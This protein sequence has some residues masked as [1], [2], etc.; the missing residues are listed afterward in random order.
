MVEN[1]F[2]MHA[3]ALRRKLYHKRV[4]SLEELGQ[5]PSLVP[6]LDDFS[7]MDRCTVTRSQD[8]VRADFAFVYLED[9]D[10]TTE[11]LVLDSKPCPLPDGTMVQLKVCR[12]KNYVAP[13]E[14][15]LP[16]W[17]RQSG[18][19][20]TLPAHAKGRVVMTGI[21]D[22]MPEAEIKELL[23]TFGELQSYQLLGEADGA[24]RACCLFDYEDEADDDKAIDALNGIDITDQEKLNVRKVGAGALVLH[25]TTTQSG[26]DISEEE[27]ERLILKTLV[28]VS[29]GL[30]EALQLAAQLQ[31]PEKP[32][33]PGTVAVKK[34]TKILALLNLFDGED[35]ENHESFEHIKAEIE[36]EAE[37]YG[38]VV[39]LTIPRDYPPPP[40]RRTAPPKP[41]LLI[42]PQTGPAKAAQ[43]LHITDGSESKE[44][45][46]A[47]GPPPG[48]A[49][50]LNNDALI[51]LSKL[52]EETTKI[53]DENTERLRKWES[54]CE[55]L[56]TIYSEEKA[57]W[58]KEIQDPI[59]NGV[60][61]VFIEYWTADEA[62]KAQV[63]LAGRQFDGRTVIT[64]FIPEEWMYAANEAAEETFDD[65]MKG[66]G[67]DPETFAIEDNPDR[68]APESNPD[69]E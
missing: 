52:E 51:P 42:E 57:K 27:H 15:S 14:M 22:S 59:K 63:A 56:D 60:G 44:A 16:S 53:Q 40:E 48:Y 5:D 36:R 64:S 67:V 12:P 69:P 18:D 6:K 65:I 68:A 34:P 33:M 43:M 8:G 11:C 50:D 23:E 20:L 24:S 46:H 66:L 4:K 38:R 31:N 10:L 35:L 9:E 62:H 1:Y 47:H 3:T 39:T 61:K 17:L 21:P 2:K 29:K 13:T 49:L 25:G 37:K 26:Q 41:D 28:N 7:G 30:H 19:S 32:A 58:D 55:E 54:E 45:G